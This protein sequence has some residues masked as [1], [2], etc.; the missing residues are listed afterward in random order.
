MQQ[1]LKDMTLIDYLNH[2][3]P[4]GNLFYDEA[5]QAFDQAGINRWLYDGERWLEQWVHDNAPE[6]HERFIE[7]RILRW[8][9]LSGRV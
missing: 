3:F 8:F 1:H 4:S 7:Q 5:G 6:G 9:Q 2:Y